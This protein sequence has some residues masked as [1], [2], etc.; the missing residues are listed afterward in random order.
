MHYSEWPFIALL[1][2]YL[3]INF[4]ITLNSLICTIKYEK[5][6]RVNSVLRTTSIILLAK[7]DF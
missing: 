5:T 4:I 6:F 7:R 1:Y 2:L 3:V